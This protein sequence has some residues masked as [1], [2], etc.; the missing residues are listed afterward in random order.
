MKD[1]EANIKNRKDNLNLIIGFI[2]KRVIGTQYKYWFV[3]N[4]YCYET[5]DEK[6]NTTKRFLKQQIQKKIIYKAILMQQ[7]QCT[8]TTSL[9]HV[10]SYGYLFNRY[11]FYVYFFL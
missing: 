11:V 10:F 1:L 2:V 6:L 9:E 8:T 7:Q 4:N 5:I 3:E